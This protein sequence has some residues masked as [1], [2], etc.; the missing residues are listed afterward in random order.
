MSNQL[1][2]MFRAPLKKYLWLLIKTCCY[3]ACILQVAFLIVEQIS[4]TQTE[5]STKEVK[6]EEIEFPV[7][8]KICFKNSFDLDK[9]KEAGYKSVWDY[10]K[11][12]SKFNDSLYGW[13]GHTRNG[14]VGPGVKG[15]TGVGRIR[16]IFITL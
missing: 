4:P 11:G 8:F 10:F 3:L 7:I 9:V 15:E 16:L 14:S 13:A 1:T 6:M 12:E 5:T 2:K